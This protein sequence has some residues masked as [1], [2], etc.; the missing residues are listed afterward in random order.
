M[1]PRIGQNQL[2]RA[3]KLAKALIAYFK[4]KHKS[5][6]KR[7]ECR[8]ARAKFGRWGYNQPR[9]EME[10][11]LGQKSPAEIAEKLEERNE[12]KE[13]DRSCQRSR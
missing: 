2:R 1:R 9:E 6:E 3:K 4:A 10:R 8:R 5:R 7:L 12:T 11:I 13:F